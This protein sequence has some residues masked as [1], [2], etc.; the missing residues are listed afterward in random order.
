MS[1]KPTSQTAHD[2]VTQFFTS[3]ALVNGQAYTI[4][5]QRHVLIGN[6]IYLRLRLQTQHGQEV[7][8][9]FPI[10]TNKPAQLGLAEG[11]H[12]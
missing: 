3:D 6:Y 1:S 7:R 12:E 8:L 2:L 9:D 10:E 5:E 11:D 4:Q